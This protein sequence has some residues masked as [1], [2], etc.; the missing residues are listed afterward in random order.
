VVERPRR[1][2]DKIPG[3]PDLQPRFSDAPN[4]VGDLLP[5]ALS[6]PNEALAIAQDLLKSRP[7]PEVASYAHQTAGIVYRDFGQMSLALEELRAAVRCAQSAGTDERLGDVLATYGA[8][9]AMAGRTGE[10][11]LQLD[12]AMALAHGALLARVRLRRAHV[13]WM[14]G[15]HREALLDLRLAIRSTRRNGDL[16]W[17]ARSLNNRCIVHLALGELRR[18]EADATRAGQLFTTLGQELESVH[19]VHNRALVELGRGDLPAALSFLDAAADRYRQLGVPMPELEIDRART[20]LAAGLAH[21]AVSSLEQALTEPKVQPTKRAELALAAA[22]AC[23]AAGDAPRAG[24]LADDAA[25]R[26]GNQRRPRWEAQARFVSLQARQAGGRNDRRLLRTVLALAP[27]LA[28]LRAEE[29]PFAYL[30]AGRIA[31]AC[32]EK[33]QAQSALHA[34]ARYRLVGPPL[35]RAS[36]WLAM[37]MAADGAVGSRPM[38]AA[39]RHGLDALDEHRLLFCAELKA[40]ATEHGREFAERALTETLRRGRNRDLLRW[41][42]RCRAT[43][44][45]VPAV[46]PPDDAALAG[47]LAG[48]R[49]AVRRI[50]AAR[51]T[52]TITPGLQR[53]RAEWESAVRRRRRHE[54]GDRASPSRLD[55]N[56]LLQSLGPCQMIVLVEIQ[57]VLYALTIRDGRVSRHRVGGMAEAIRE[58]KLARF[59]LRRIAIGQ[60]K[61]LRPTGVNLERALLG[62]VARGC[63]AE[64]V[65]LVPPSSLHHVPWGLLPTLAEV[66]LTVAP[67]AGMW[68]RARRS[69]LPAGRN[70]A[71]VVGPGLA[72]GDAEAAQLAQFHPQPRILVGGAATVPDTLSALDGA[73]LGHIAA[74]GT[75]RADS[76]LFSCLHLHDGPLTI[77]DLDRLRQPPHLVILSA[78]DTAVSA[79]V[80]SDEVLGLVTG[81]LGLGVAG[82]LASVVPVNDAATVPVML[83]VHRALRDGSSLA[84]AWLAARTA[85]RGDYIAAAAAG[86]FTA[87]G[88]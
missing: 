22:A 44:V 84:E 70:V 53:E 42:E 73:W 63:G 9:L 79:P 6:Q 48:Y 76:P 33:E 13:F 71:L 41:S 66:P 85:A 86:S 8:T 23:L 1:Q 51:G 52:G 7:D 46:H 80:G 18:A 21:E 19:A 11:L 15:R 35:S 45:S 74:H 30:L 34:A 3:W 57:Q 14:L 28:E 62:S 40:Y 24:E 64:P 58:A 82:V 50:N 39:C 88:A 4:A 36:G 5:L 83:S 81:L 27:T 54:R 60:A 26:F 31:L 17:E 10:G 68:L 29:A 32:G 47:E 20:F 59:A 61:E 72:T 67:S 69:S 37:A 87:W 38:L 55:L 12:R 77:H 25:R 65:I 75:F 56:L 16:L 2:K 78:C 49:D 43:A